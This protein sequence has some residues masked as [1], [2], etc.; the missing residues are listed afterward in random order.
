MLHPFNTFSTTVQKIYAK[1]Q[2]KLHQEMRSSSDFIGQ[3][4]HA[5]KRWSLPLHTPEADEPLPPSEASKESRSE[6]IKGVRNSIDGLTAMLQEIS[7]ERNILSNM[8]TDSLASRRKSTSSLLSPESRAPAAR[9]DASLTHRKSKTVASIP[10]QEFTTP[11]STL[12]ADSRIDVSAQFSGSSTSSLQSI[13]K[14]PTLE[15]QLTSR[16]NSQH[17]DAS[18]RTS[19]SVRTSVGADASNAAAT[20]P[21]SANTTTRTNV[22]TTADSTLSLD[23]MNSAN[24]TINRDLSDT[25]NTAV[26]NISANAS[27]NSLDGVST[28]PG[29]PGSSARLAAS[30]AAA[31]AASAVAAAQSAAHASA[32]AASPILEEREYAAGVDPLDTASVQ[33]TTSSYLNSNIPP[34][35]PG[36]P[37]AMTRLRMLLN[38]D[39]ENSISVNLLRK[40]HMRDVPRR[41]VHSASIESLSTLR[42]KSSLRDLL[43]DPSY[44]S[45]DN[46]SFSGIV[47]TTMNANGVPGPAVTDRDE[48]QR[49][50]FHN[51]SSRRRN[52]SDSGILYSPQPLHTPSTAPM[53]S[54]LGQP[55][56]PGVPQAQPTLDPLAS[57]PYP[58]GVLRD[59]SMPTPRNAYY[60]KAALQQ[61]P[62]RTPISDLSHVTEVSESGDVGEQLSAAAL[63]D[64]DDEVEQRRRHQRRSGHVERR[65]N[66]ERKRRSF[67]KEGIEE[68]LDSKNA[69][70]NLDEIDLPR[71]ERVLL[72]KFITSLSRLSIEI[73]MDESKREEGRRRLNNALKALDGWI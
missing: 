6:Q 56:N 35:S 45:L 4:K 17:S 14:T 28:K 13:G 52:A 53:N 48:G 66:K 72:D 68:L 55:L 23:R 41:P 62:T 43:T 5:F 24:T 27:G 19:R 54:P 2:K 16:I 69:Q 36:R 10:S 26:G 34:R 65:P 73:Q 42:S 60:E 39:M 58:V 40:E 11:Y 32:R 30:Q 71:E 25:T 70:Y 9:S 1:A 44:P 64:L 49:R 33:R 46:R 67:T 15:S 20:Q 7:T 61:R 59:F 37:D 50:R 51:P 57:D 29:A 18:Q 22:D 63:D 47:S 21:S 8:S 31:A 38:E 3:T 12:L